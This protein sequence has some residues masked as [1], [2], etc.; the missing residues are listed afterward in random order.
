[1]ILMNPM[2]NGTNNQYHLSATNKLTFSLLYIY[3]NKNYT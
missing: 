3:S 2:F 1:M